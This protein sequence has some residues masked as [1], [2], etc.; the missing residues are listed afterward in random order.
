MFYL[1]PPPVFMLYKPH[2]CLI[3]QRIQPK[4]KRLNQEVTPEHP[5]TTQPDSVQHKESDGPSCRHTNP[6][7]IHT[8]S[9]EGAFTANMCHW[10]KAH[11]PPTFSPWLW[12]PSWE[13]KPDEQAL[14]L[15]SEHITYDQEEETGTEPA[16]ERGETQ[17]ATNWCSHR[18]ISTSSCDPWTWP[19]PHR[20]NPR[21]EEAAEVSHLR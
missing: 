21:Q 18:Q 9:A 10:I 4:S 13:S 3:Q 11:L 1:L 14:C 8:G 17:R 7:E 6:G 5:A 15:W 2:L 12:T 20:L 16:L 19:Q